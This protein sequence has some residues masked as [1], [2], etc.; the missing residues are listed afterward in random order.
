[1]ELR[2]IK[3]RLENCIQPEGGSDSYLVASW[4]AGPPDVPA[5][6]DRSREFHYT[7]VVLQ[8]VAVPARVLD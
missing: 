7:Q 1:M 8:A 5:V 4:Q 3:S 2:T 6:L